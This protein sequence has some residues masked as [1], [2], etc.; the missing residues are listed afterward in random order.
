MSDMR[1]VV[2][3]PNITSDSVR[4][5]PFPPGLWR[6]SGICQQLRDLP[7]IP[8]ENTGKGGVHKADL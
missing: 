5:K 2:S 6:S 8:G 7:K 4:H 3:H 1:G